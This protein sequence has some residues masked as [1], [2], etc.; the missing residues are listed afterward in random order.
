MV[1]KGHP[2]PTRAHPK[3]EIPVVFPEAP[4]SSDPHSDVFFMKKKPL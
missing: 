1:K 4:P 2:S 3:N